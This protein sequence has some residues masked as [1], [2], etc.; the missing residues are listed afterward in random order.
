M[1]GRIDG[2]KDGWKDGLIQPD[3]QTQELRNASLLFPFEI[4]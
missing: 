3:T 2:W 4:G 1:D